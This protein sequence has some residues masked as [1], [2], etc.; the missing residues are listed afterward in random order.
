M[1]SYDIIDH[2]DCFNYLLERNTYA[3]RIY[4]TSTKQL[5]SVAYVEKLANRWWYS[6][7]YDYW[8]SFGSC[9]YRYVVRFTN[10]NEERHLSCLSQ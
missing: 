3:N 5:S 4:I 2:R 1:E 8:S 10:D 7:A 6:Y 9:F